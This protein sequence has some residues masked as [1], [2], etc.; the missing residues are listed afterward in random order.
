M[1]GLEIFEKKNERLIDLVVYI[2]TLSAAYFSDPPELLSKMNY[3]CGRVVL[4]LGGKMGRPG[5]PFPED[6]ALRELLNNVS[7][8]YKDYS[9]MTRHFENL[10]RE[11]EHAI[12]RQIRPEQKGW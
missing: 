7:K 3:Y 6:L 4:S 5:E 1:K 2:F 8:K 12:D 9:G 10:I 11:V